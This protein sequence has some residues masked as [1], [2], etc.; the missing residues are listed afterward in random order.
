MTQQKTLRAKVY[1]ILRPYIQDSPGEWP[2]RLFDYFLILLILSNAVAMMLDTVPEF[3]A[4]WKQ[5]LRIFDLFSVAIF[6]V[7]YVARL[8]TCVELHDEKH[9]NE[10]LWKRRCRYLVSPMA[11][12]DLLAILPFYL[13]M[14]ISIDLRVLRLLRLTRLIKLGRYSRSAQLLWQVL[15]N[16][17]KTLIAA[18]SI[19]LIVM[20]FAATGIYY[21]EREAQP[22]VFGTIPS[23]LWWALVTLTTVGY[24]DVVPITVGGKVFGGCITL[25]GVALYAVPAGILSSSFTAQLQLRRDRFRDVVTNA[26][27]DGHLSMTEMQH[28]D[29]IR[30]ILNLDGEEAELIIRL[31]RHRKE[32]SD[33]S[34]QGGKSQL[35]TTSTSAE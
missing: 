18:L 7:E 34:H 14:F 26:M 16:E 3:T 29:K 4:R 31:L 33:G 1:R 15:R 19:M 20:T 22:D 5:E 13:S 9:G 2:S 6:T 23:S 8:W 27:E 24:G 30:E 21:I 12:I 25:M 17:A 11:I 10:P 35:A 28:I 32:S